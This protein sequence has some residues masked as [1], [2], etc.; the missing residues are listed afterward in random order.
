MDIYGLRAYQDFSAE[1]GPIL[2]THFMD[3]WLIKRSAPRM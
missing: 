3:Y 1:Y 2:P